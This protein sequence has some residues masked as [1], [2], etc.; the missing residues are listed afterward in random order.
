MVTAPRMLESRRIPFGGDPME[1]Q[2]NRE[3]RQK[4]GHDIDWAKETPDRAVRVADDFWIIATRHHPGGSQAFPEIN[5]RCLIFRL[6]EG[7]K[8]TLLV[9]NGVEASAITEVKR[10]ERET[11]LTVRYVLSPGGGH[12]VLMPPWVEAFP[13][14]SVLVGPARI[15]RTASGR[16]LLAMPRVATYDPNQLLPQFAGQLEFVSFNGL[17]GAPDN[18]S[19]GEGGPDGI[20]LMMKMMFAML[21]KMKDPVDEL[22]TFHVPTRTV[23]GGENLG[24]MYPKAAHAKLPGMLKSMI[25]PDAVYLF[26]DARK[27]ADGAIVDA[28]WRRILEW[29]ARNVITYHDPPGHAFQGDGREALQAAARAL[30]QI[31]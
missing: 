10:L 22:W 17:F 1:M 21:F 5:N 15:P 23:I 30:R 14:A 4:A 25:T 18:Q 27:V 19:P 12:H 6:V 7:G 26:K 3:L 29:P 8:H 13:D 28:C 2:V 31:L 24:W 11:N 20:R 16:K 9:I